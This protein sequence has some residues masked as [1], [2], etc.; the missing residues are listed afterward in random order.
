MTTPPSEL[1]ALVHWERLTLDLLQ[2]TARFPKSTR[3]TLTRRIE[4]AALEILECLATVR[5]E[6]GPAK[7]AR[8]VA[9]DAT[10]TRLRVLLRLA[11]GLRQLDTTGYEHVSRQIDEAGRMLGGWRKSVGP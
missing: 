7:V 9:I 10:L 4:D 2:R 3:A 8:L 1:P 5:F 11:H 6:G